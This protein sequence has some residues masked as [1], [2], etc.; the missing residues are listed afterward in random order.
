MRRCLPFIAVLS[1]MPAIA[2]AQASRDDGIR[3]MVRGDY[4]TAARILNAL[5]DNTAQPDP[6]AQFLLA[7]LYD[8]GHGVTRNP[9]RAC[10]LFLDAVK[11]DNPFMQ[12][13]SQ[14]SNLAREQ[15]GPVAPQ[16]C[17]AGATWAP[18]NPPVTLTL[19]PNHAVAITDTSMTVSYQGA[20]GRIGFGW[21]PGTVLLPVRH[22]AL[23]VSNPVA[24]RR[25]FLERFMWVPDAPRQATAWTLG[26]GLYE[27]VGKEIRSI[28]G[29][30]S[31]TV[32][33]GSRPPESFDLAS[34]ARVRMTADS[35]AEWVITGSTNPR[36]G[37]VPWKDP[38]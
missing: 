17:V 6:A 30:R 27:I 3:A 37:V 36:S 9:P 32:V 4:A 12:Q 29:E 23:D 10:G 11:P 1:L 18:D 21:L 31:L 38:R 13:A 34:L 5:A 22:T 16:L 15:L 25:Q 24:V 19:A 2:A 14:L 7:I 28:T 20:E 8:T 26:W 33:S 35:A